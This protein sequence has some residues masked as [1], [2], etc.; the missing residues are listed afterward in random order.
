MA[1]S[2]IVPCY[3]VDSYMPRAV[4]CMAKQ[5]LNSLQVIWVDD[6]SPDETALLCDKALLSSPREY[7]AL[8]SNNGGLSAARN[9]GMIVSWGEYIGF[10]D[11]DDY[12]EKDMFELMFKQISSTSN[13][14]DMIFCSYYIESDFGNDE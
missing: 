9:H 7:Y 4:A 5:T 14:I 6:G 2:V 1:V 12:I 3:N 13:L 10:M 8:H 11:P